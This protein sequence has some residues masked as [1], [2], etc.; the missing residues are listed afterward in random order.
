MKLNFTIVADRPYKFQVL[1]PYQVGSGDVILK[2][3]ISDTGAVLDVQLIRGDEPFASVAIAAVRT[4][5][6]RPAL[7]DGR[8]VAF[9][10]RVQIPFRIRS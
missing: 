3:R 10:R 9:T 5:R 4:W 2:V 1:C 8:P 6:Y 7:V